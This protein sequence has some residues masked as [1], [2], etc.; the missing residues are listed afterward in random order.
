MSAFCDISIT[1]NGRI[2]SIRNGNKDWESVVAHDRLAVHISK[3]N[4]QERTF[5]QQYVYE[6]NTLFVIGQ[7]YESVNLHQLLLDCLSHVQRDDKFNDPAGHYILF[8]H[9]RKTHVHVFTNRLGSCHAYWKKEANNNTIATSYLNLLGVTNN[10]ALDWEGISGFFAMG[11]FPDDRTYL[12]CIKI[13]EPASC[14]TFDSDLNL[15]H[16]KRY[17]HWH[18]RESDYSASDNIDRADSVLSRSLK[19]SLAD[20]KVS[21]PLSG[22]LDSR[23]LAG[24]ISKAENKNYNGLWSY[25]YGYNK[26][27][28][29]IEIAKR[30]AKAKDIPFDGYVVPNYLFDKMDTIA[31]SIDLFAYVDGARQASILEELDGHCDVVVGGHWG[32]V[33]FDNI[34]VATDE[35]VSNYF[36]TKIIKRGSNWLLNE[37]CRQHVDDPRE[38]VSNYF[39][40]HLKRYDNIADKS[41]KLKTYKTDQWSF[42]WAAVGVRMYQAA[43]MPVL[44]FYDNRIVDL[45]S[46]IPGAQLQGRYLQIELL[47]KN[48]PELAAIKWQDYESN[49]YC[50]KYLNNR[51]IIYR[52]YKK[53][54]RML[55]GQQTIIRNW[56]L[57]YLNPEGRRNLE[58]ILIGQGILD[59][60][61]SKEKVQALIDD[62]YN[63]PTAANGYTISMLHTFAQFLKRLNA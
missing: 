39:D 27:S 11:Y 3:P 12:D 9:D 17:W 47:K 8:V 51:N 29:E 46:S 13:F 19:Y 10:K 54:K 16:Q 7:F 44:P 15:L 49:L 33:W 34:A 30:I 21:L 42:R 22:G 14:Y 28:I 55:S 37:I 24:I 59:A 60:V 58:D 23:T 56:E 62:F 25:S 5:Y 38:V 41:F 45:F 63:N 48:Y 18:Y 35:D 61:I 1:T 52:A 6:G 2:P 20:K 36:Q 43:A 50:Y 53:A 4:K 40:S 31:E 57:F 32:D 26:Q